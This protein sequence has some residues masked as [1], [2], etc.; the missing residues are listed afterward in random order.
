MQPRR[1]TFEPM[2]PGAAATIAPVLAG[3]DPWATYKSEAVALQSYLSTPEAGAPRFQILDQGEPAGAIGIRENWLRGPY[4]QFLAI[5]PAYQDRGIGTA[6]LAWFEGKARASA[7]K[8]LWVAASEFNT[9]A[10]VFYEKHDFEQV[11]KLD[12]LVAEGHAELLMRKPLLAF[13]A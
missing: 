3:I 10:I 4:L 13:A 9:R 5:L 8:N 12:G 11:A 1:V 2:T 6:A 7:A